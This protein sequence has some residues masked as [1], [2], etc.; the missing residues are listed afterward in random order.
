MGYTLDCN[1]TNRGQSKCKSTSH[2]VD[3]I[4][5][6]FKVHWA[7]P[8]IG[9]TLFGIVNKWYLETSLRCQIYHKSDPQNQGSKIQIIPYR[10]QYNLRNVY[11]STM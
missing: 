10:F 7:C 6:V 5:N 1:S 8:K 9:V 4:C 2:S 3:H 11:Y